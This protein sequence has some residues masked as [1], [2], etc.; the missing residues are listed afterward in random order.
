METCNVNLLLQVVLLTFLRLIAGPISLSVV[1]GTGAR[2]EPLE[3]LLVT[4]DGPCEREQTELS[5][6]RRGLLGYVRPGP[7][8]AWAYCSEDG[9]QLLANVTLTARDT[10]HL[11]HLLDRLRA[12]NVTLWM[13]RREFSVCCYKRRHRSVSFV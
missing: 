4:L 6:V 3:W 1:G 11:T 10:L 8:I 9:A 12:H 7:R 2:S 13:E 5:V